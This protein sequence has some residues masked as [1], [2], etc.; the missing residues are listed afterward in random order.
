MKIENPNKQYKSNTHIVHSCY[1]HVIFTPK[2][3][4]KVL[5]GKVE[6]RVKE[7]FFEIS[8]KYK[9]EIT[10]IE[11]MPEHVHMVISCDPSFGIVKCIHRLKGNS[12]KILRD[13]FP[14]LLK[15]P[16]LWTRSCFISSVG[17]VTLDVVKKYIEDQKG[18]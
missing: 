3:R 10:D 17:S 4:K 16:T 11:I 6:N 2:Y 8:N 12:S 14:H 15:M 5:I 18:K 7:L 1:Y 13:E 9:F